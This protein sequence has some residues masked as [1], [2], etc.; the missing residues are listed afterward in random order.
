MRKG[1]I[2]LACNEYSF[3][4]VNYADAIRVLKEAPSPLK[5]LI[6][7][8]NPQKLFTTSQSKLSYL[9]KLHLIRIDLINQK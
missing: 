7:R 1:D 9:N 2:I 4:T 5:L 3:R 6:L 8:E